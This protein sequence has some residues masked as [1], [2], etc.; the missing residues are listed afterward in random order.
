MYEKDFLQPGKKQ[1]Q[2]KLSWST[3]HQ[4]ANHILGIIGPNGAGKSTLLK[5][6]LGFTRPDSGTITIDGKAPHI[7][8]SRKKIGYLT[9]NPYDY[10]HLFADALL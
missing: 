2:K 1:T 3:I 9:N 7:P 5:M 6:I 4:N 8:E 10:G